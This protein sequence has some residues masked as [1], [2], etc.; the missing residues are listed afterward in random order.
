MKK[1]SGILK[2]VFV[3]FLIAILAINVSVIIQ[4]NTNKDEVPKIFGYKP[5]IVLSGS[6][7]SEIHVGDLILVKEVN[8][9]TLKEKD[10]IAYRDSDNKVTTHRIIEVL[11]DDQGNI[12]FITKGDSNNTDDGE[13]KASQ[14]EGIYEKRFGKL[15]KAVMFIQE[16]LGFAIVVL[17]IFIICLLIYLW[18]N[19]NLNKE[20]KFA[21]E[22][23]KKAFEEFKKSRENNNN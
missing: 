7:E 14:V 16:P 3:L 9:D 8:V 5:F 1:V 13:I 12:S 19:K 23:E 6:M 17:S 20:I 4:A 18:Q 11:K 2:I 21:N 10:I 15:G 22:E